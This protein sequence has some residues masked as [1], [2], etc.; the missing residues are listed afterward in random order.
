MPSAQERKGRKTPEHPHDKMT[1]ELG[2]KTPPCVGLSQDR[3][4]AP[5]AL[6]TAKGEEQVCFL[7][8]WGWGRGLPHSPET[9][10]QAPRCLL[11]VLMPHHTAAPQAGATVPLTGEGTMTRTCPRPWLKRQKPAWSH[12][13]CL[14]RAGIKEESG[15]AVQAAEGVTD[16][17]LPGMQA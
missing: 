11:R 8:P 7:C 13:P 3:A 4:S 5:G 15:P 10:I 6:L 16:P 1:T 17:E 2:A 12:G 9:A 14:P